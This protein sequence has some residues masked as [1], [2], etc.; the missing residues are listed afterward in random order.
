MGRNLTGLTVSGD[1]IVGGSADVKI[2]DVSGYVQ[3]EEMFMPTLTV[4]EHLMIQAGIRL[5]GLPSR[6]IKEYVNK[7]IDE[8]G[9]S[10]CRDTVIGMV[11]VK[12]GISGKLIWFS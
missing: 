4:N 11:G 3:Q 7:V 2:R 10:S 9:L 8:L 6:D 12:K 1:I 5:A